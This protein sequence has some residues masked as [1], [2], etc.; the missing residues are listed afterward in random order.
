VDDDGARSTQ[1]TTGLQGRRKVTGGGVV[2][3]LSNRPKQIAAVD[4]RADEARRLIWTAIS[5]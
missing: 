2:K 1:Q 4:F 3:V 5:V